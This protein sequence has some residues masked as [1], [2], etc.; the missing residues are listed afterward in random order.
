MPFATLVEQAAGHRPKAVA[1]HLCLVVAEATQRG[2]DGVVEDRP[3]F[4]TEAWKEP[5]PP[6]ELLGSFHT[7][8]TTTRLS[9]AKWPT[10]SFT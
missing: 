6:P 2:I 8:Q 5:M 3:F 1:G 10:M 4:R 9:L 7:S